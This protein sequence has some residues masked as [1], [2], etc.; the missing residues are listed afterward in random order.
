MGRHCSVYLK[1]INFLT[2]S[3]NSMNPV[4]L[5]PGYRWGSEAQG[6]E[7]L[8]DADPHNL[9]PESVLTTTTNHTKITF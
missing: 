3:D 7:V 8:L 2:F 5:S 1:C 6:N 4:L 9:A